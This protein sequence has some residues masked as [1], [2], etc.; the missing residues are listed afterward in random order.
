[1]QATFPSAQTRHPLIMP[2][3]STHL[4]TVF[5]NAA[6]DHPRW[7]VGDYSYA[8]AHIVPDDWAGTLAPYLFPMSAE[9]LVI[10]KFCQIASGVQFITSSANHR[11]NGISSYPFAIFDGMDASRPSLPEPG[12]DTII[13]NDVWI[14]T[15]AKILP[16]TRIGSG[17]IVGA[18]AVV[19]GHVDDYTIVGGNPARKIRARFDH[20]TAQHLLRIGWWHWPIEKILRNEALIMGGDVAALDAAS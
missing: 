19:A 2:D 5:L 13:G 1:M 20:E 8:S 12:P 9:K 6:I 11:Y 4:S 7:F 10:G 14:G 16:G 17:V 18:G 3:G 15:G